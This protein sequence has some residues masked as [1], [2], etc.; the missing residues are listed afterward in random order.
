[1]QA[2][3]TRVISR[4]DVNRWVTLLLERSE[5]VA[6]V[7]VSGG[8]VFYAPISRA[9]D[10]LWE[11][12]NSILPP[13]QYLIPQ[14][15][16]IAEIHRVNGT[17]HIEPAPEPV[18]RVLFNVRSCDAVGLQYLRLMHERDLRDDHVVK[19]ADAL[20]VITLACP[21]ACENGFC[22]CG[23]AGPFLYGGFDIQ[24]TDLGE[25]ILAEP[26]SEKG[27]ALLERDARLFQTATP[28]QLEASR[29]LE[30]EAL[31]EFG[32]NRCHF[33]SAM[34]RLSTRRV[35]DE[36][37]DT[38]SAWCLEC[39]ACTF[40]CPTCYCFSVAD[41]KTGDDAWQRER[42]WDSCQYCSFTAE[43]SGHN[44]R[45]KR[46]ERMKRRFYHKVSAQYTQRDGRVGC[47]GCGRC[48]R[49]CMGVTDMPTV[50]RAIR[51]GKLE[52]EVPA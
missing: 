43:A 15:D 7:Q 51:R 35:P 22:V 20:T 5:V 10:V 46:R 41:R 21:H 38:M 4:R 9:D 2:R 47:V 25:E 40:V 23:D 24:L 48:V 30:Q 11:F 28:Q 34:R 45:V 29:R 26:G 19:R 12:E 27:E 37:W 13:K 3:T 8:D 42:I 33:A 36:L 6:P 52:E 32:D 16:P 39:G 44:P 18:H 31:A 14:T 49:V 1:M 17:H 50:V